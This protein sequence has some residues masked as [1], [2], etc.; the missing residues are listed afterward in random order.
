MATTRGDARLLGSVRASPTS[1]I[2]KEERT[3]H[4]LVIVSTTEFAEDAAYQMQQLKSKV[5]DK[6]GQ[7]S[8]V[9]RVCVLC[10][11]IDCGCLCLDQLK[12]MTSG[13]FNDLQSRYG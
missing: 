10:L 5:S 3:I 6:A 8:G 13:F 11:C 7:V 2:G 12:Q 9:V 4:S 1:G